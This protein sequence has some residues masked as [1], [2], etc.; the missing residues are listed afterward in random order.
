MRN[1][2]FISEEQKLWE[3]TFTGDKY[4]LSPR[5]NLVCKEDWDRIKITWWD[6][7][8]DWILKYL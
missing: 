5:G 8:K 2:K 4:I 1:H 6:L 3:D 7:F